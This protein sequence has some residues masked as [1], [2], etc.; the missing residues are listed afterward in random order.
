MRAGVRGQK[1]ALGA[2]LL[3]GVGLPSARLRAQP[4]VPRLGQ[5]VVMAGTT[6]GAAASG[7]KLG[8]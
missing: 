8:A 3:H 4:P 7:A 1:R 2:S 5:L 6:Q